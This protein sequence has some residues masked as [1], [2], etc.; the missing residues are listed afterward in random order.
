LA[1][2][3]KVIEQITCKRGGVHTR[4]AIPPNASQIAMVVFARYRRWA[5]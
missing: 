3:P 1:I 2:I 4:L 5:D